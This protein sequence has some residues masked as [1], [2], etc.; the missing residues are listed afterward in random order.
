MIRSTFAFPAIIAG[1]TLIGLIVALTGDG[2]PDVLSWFALALPI[3][4]L[5][6]AYS[7]RTQ[8]KPKSKK[9]K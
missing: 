7:R 6:W 1:L 2:A 5:G 3:V 9:G 4:A 8:F